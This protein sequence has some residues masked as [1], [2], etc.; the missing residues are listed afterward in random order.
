VVC[1]NPKV[2]GFGLR[3]QGSGFRPASVRSRQQGDGD[4]YLCWRSLHTAAAAG[5][6]TRL[7]N[8]SLSRTSYEPHLVWGSRLQ[9]KEVRGSGLQGSTGLGFRGAGFRNLMLGFGD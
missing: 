3:V 5:S 6:G 7:T 8:D 9:F 1:R 4:W 2:S